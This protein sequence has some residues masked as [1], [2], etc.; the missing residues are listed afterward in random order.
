MRELI[1]A[2]TGGAIALE[3]Q[4]ERA[5]K[6]GW[7][8]G[9]FPNCVLA[10]AARELTGV[11]IEAPAGGTAEV[12]VDYARDP[13]AG[14]PEGVRAGIVAGYQSG[15]LVGQLA[16]RFGLTRDATAAALDEW[17][18]AR[19]ETRP[20]GR[21]RRATLAVKHLVAPGYQRV[22]DRVK[23]LADSGK[24]LREVAEELGI[25]RNTVTS[26]WRHW[27]ESRGLAVPDGRTRRKSLTRKDSSPSAGS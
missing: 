19:G 11:A 24:L 6:R 23:G 10:A 15:A 25:D 22:A 5:P 14:V 9:R 13:K 1:A 17:Y 2:V 21:S 18:A 16:E 12:V 20:D 7:L 27:H 8:R 3:Q 4:G 26:A